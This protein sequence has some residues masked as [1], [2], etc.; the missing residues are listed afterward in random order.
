[1]LSSDR[2][3]DMGHRWSAGAPPFRVIGRKCPRIGPEMIESKSAVFSE[4]SE[5]RRFAALNGALRDRETL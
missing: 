1:M 2:A 3:E 4:T 5:Y